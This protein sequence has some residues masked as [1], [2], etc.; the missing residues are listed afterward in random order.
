MGLIEHFL[1]MLSIKPY[2]ALVFCFIQTPA[3]YA[4]F[5]G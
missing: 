1:E 3:L 4:I 2:I 5:P